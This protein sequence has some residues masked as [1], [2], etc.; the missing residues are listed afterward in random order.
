MNK[1]QYPHLLPAVMDIRGYIRL[2]TISLTS[3]TLG[4]KRLAVTYLVPE[5]S[6]VKS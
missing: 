1:K 6:M 2:S 4:K 5:N 3:H